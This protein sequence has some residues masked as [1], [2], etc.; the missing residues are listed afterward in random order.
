MPVYL[1]LLML[2]GAVEGRIDGAPSA[3]ALAAATMLYLGVSN[4]AHTAEP[5]TLL[6]GVNLAAC[7]LLVADSL[8]PE[9]RAQRQLGPAGEGA[10]DGLLR[11]EDTAL[12][13][14]LTLGLALFLTLTMN[15]VAGLRT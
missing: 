5:S 11:R 12:A 13:L 14:A 6:F 9:A 1:P 4:I 8:R 7:A 3:S 10:D 2:C 15:T